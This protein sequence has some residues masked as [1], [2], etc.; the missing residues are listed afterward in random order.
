MTPREKDMLEAVKAYIAAH[1]LSPT[2]EELCGT[3]GLASKSSAMRLLDGLE[4]D[5]FIRRDSRRGR[6]RNIVVLDGIE[7]EFDRLCASFGKEAVLA[8]ALRR[9]S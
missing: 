4:A 9:A 5:G 8:E 3:L 6:T 1:H 2:L 7:A